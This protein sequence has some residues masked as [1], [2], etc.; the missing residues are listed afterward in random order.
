MNNATQQF[1]RTTLA[2][3][4]VADAFDVASDT[5]SNE[6]K[7]ATNKYNKIAERMTFA[8]P[9]AAGNHVYSKQYC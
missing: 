6:F 1:S 8:T 3:F 9:K 2:I 5:F 7:G 4:C